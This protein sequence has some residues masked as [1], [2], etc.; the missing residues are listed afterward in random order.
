VDIGQSRHWSK[1]TL[2]KAEIGQ[3]GH[4]SKQALVEAGIGQ[5]RH[6]SNLNTFVKRSWLIFLAYFDSY[7]SVYMVDSNTFI[8]Y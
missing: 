3:S 4:W 5:S 2:A 7:F 6:W 8:E 1:L